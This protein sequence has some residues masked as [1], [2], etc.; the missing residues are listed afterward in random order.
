M[1]FQLLHPIVVAARGRGGCELEDELA[2]GGGGRGAKR[3]WARLLAFFVR[4]EWGRVHISTFL[5]LSFSCGGRDGVSTETWR[6][7]VSAR[8]GRPGASSSA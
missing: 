5:L 4:G 6:L 3:F 2:T 7:D 8:I 1:V